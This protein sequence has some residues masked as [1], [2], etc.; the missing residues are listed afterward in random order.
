MQATG[1]LPPYLWVG[2]GLPPGLTLHQ[3]GTLTGTPTTTG[4]YTASV[5]VIDDST[6]VQIADVSLPILIQ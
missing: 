1:G 3:D 2:V 6:P 4:T 5:S